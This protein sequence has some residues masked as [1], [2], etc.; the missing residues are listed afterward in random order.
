MVKLFHSDILMAS[1]S[2][3]TFDTSLYLL[4]HLVSFAAEFCFLL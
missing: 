3:K 4:F 2:G 1:I